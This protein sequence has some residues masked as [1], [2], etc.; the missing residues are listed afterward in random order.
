V[1]SNV[2]PFTAGAS[3]YVWGFSGSESQGQWILFRSTSWTWPAASDTAPVPLYWSSKD[4]NVVVVGSLP[5]SGNGVGL[6]ATAVID[7]PPPVT[8]WAQWR[9][10]KLN[11]LVPTNPSDDADGDGVANIIE[12]ALGTEPGLAVDRPNPSNWLQTGN[13]NG[14]E[15][16][17]LRVPRR[18][19]HPVDL[20]VEISN[21]LKTWSSGATATETVEDTAQALTVRD[22]TPIG[23]GESRRFMRVRAATAP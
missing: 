16:L 15:Y 12:Y 17:E 6:R 19:D 20:V 1:T 21:D 9:Q 3:A 14:R 7:S 2:A 11:G 5:A 10:S 22:R 4:A 23:D 13:A 18:R 8:T